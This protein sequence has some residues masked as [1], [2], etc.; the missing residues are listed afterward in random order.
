MN[1]AE[2]YLQNIVENANPIR[3]VIMLY[4]KAISC[5]DEA[6]EAIEG[7]LEELENVKNK[8]E[9]LTKAT[10]ILVVLKASLDEDK[11]KEIA[12]NLD[13]IYDVLINEIVRANMVNDK[14][15]LLKI[16]NILE[17][18]RE[19]WEEAEKKVYGREEVSAK[20]DGSGP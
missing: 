5:I 6:I 10:D 19:A 20:A 16:K 8:A 2:V 14:E 9:N 18:L 7:G 17:E 11:G 15:A 12:K 13:E 4:D 1:P 3:L